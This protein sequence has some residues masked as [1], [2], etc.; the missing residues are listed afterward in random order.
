MMT[1]GSLAGVWRLVAAA[2]G[3]RAGSEPP[4]PFVYRCCYAHCSALFSTRRHKACRGA[5]RAQGKLI[6]RRGKIALPGAPPTAGRR[7]RREDGRELLL[8]VAGW[9]GRR[10]AITWSCTHHVRSRAVDL[11]CNTMLGL[12]CG[13]V[14]LSLGDR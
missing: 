2:N 8:P 12:R 3:C 13:V 5:T 10:D 6:S 11:T 1:S 7:R 9:H 4:D 14:Q